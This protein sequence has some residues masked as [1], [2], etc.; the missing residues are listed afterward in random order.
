LRFD[1]ADDELEGPAV[2]PSYN[3]FPWKRCPLPEFVG[4]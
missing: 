4:S 2:R 3:H 1:A